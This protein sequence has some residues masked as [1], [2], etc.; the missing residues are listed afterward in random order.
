M[1]LPAGEYEVRFLQNDEIVREATINIYESESPASFPVEL[2]SSGTHIQWRPEGTNAWSDL[3]SLDDIGGSGGGSTGVE[4]RISSDFIQYRNIGETTWQNL[5]DISE[6]GGGGEGDQVTVNGE[7]YTTENHGISPS[8]NPATDRINLQDFID[9]MEANQTFRGVIKEGTWQIDSTLFL[10]DGCRI[11]GDGID[12]TVIDCPTA[13]WAPLAPYENS[14]YGL[15]LDVEDSLHT[16]GV[17]LNDFTIIGADKNATDNGPL[18]RLEGLDDFTITRV[19]VVD[20]SSYGIYVTGYGVG[21]FTNDITSDFWNSTHRGVIEQCV[22]LRGQVGIGLEGGS[23]QILLTANHTYS[24]ALHGIRIASGY[25]CV[26]A[27]NTVNGSYNGFWLDRHKGIKLVHNTARDITGNAITYGGFGASDGIKST[28]LLI[29]GNET[30]TLEGGSHIS[31]SYHGTS[32]KNTIGV[33]ILGNSF[34]GPGTIRF[35]NSKRLNIQQNYSDG[36]NVI[37]GQSGATGIIC[38]NMMRIFD[39]SAGMQDLG[40]NIDPTTI[41]VV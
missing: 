1:S 23:E 17:H 13:T 8:G 28:G 30:H 15:M 4:M 22:A 20:G 9:T 40:N 31:D 29:Q 27:F 39:K 5:L 33:Q 6:L 25:D 37:R 14:Y 34:Y 12:R 41:A 36:Q 19:K 35:L 7:E 11:R 26:M 16:K 2:R 18:I 21:A 24:T 38:N 3:V 32:S 10:F